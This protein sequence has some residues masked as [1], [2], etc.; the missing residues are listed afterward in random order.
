[1]RIL[2]IHTEAQRAVLDAAHVLS[3]RTT[4]GSLCQRGKTIAQAHRRFY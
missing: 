2:K 4:H 3:R 1:M